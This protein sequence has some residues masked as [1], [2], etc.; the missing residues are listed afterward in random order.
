M[1]IVQQ[2]GGQA[3]PR[4]GLLAVVFAALAAGA[5][6]AGAWAVVFQASSPKQASANTSP[7]ASC[8]ADNVADQSGVNYPN[9]EVEP[10]VDVNPTNAKNIVAAWQQDRW[11]NGGARGLVAGVSSNGGK[12]W[13]QVVI[14]GLVACSGNPNFKRAS[15]PWVSFAP[16]GDLYQLALTTSGGITATGFPDSG[17]L[18]SKS[19]DG[20]QTWADPIALKTDQGPNVLNDK[21]SIT[22]DANDAN[23]AYAV[24]DRLEEG[25]GSA[26]TPQVFEHAIGFFGPAWF[27]R[28]TNGGQSWEPAR[29]IFDPGGVNQT[30]GNQVAVL[31]SSQG[32]DLL[33][34]FNLIAN[35]K[36]AGGIRGMNVAFVRSTDK[37]ATWSGVQLVDKLLRARVRDPETGQLV[38]TAEFNLD[39]AVDAASG[40]LYAV[41]QDARF[42][43]TGKAGIALSMS[44]DGGATWSPTIKINT[45]PGDVSAFTPAVHVLPD[46]TVGATYYDFRNNTTDPNTLP[47]D[48]WLVHCH[49]SCSSAA[50]WAQETHVAGPFDMKNAP[51]ASGLFVG[52]YEGLDNLG[53][54]FALL[55]VQAGTTPNSA[56]AF[57]STVGP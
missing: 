56:D 28:T 32:G 34:F 39:V 23:F 37:G 49:S 33:D 9:T 48:Y 43:P 53:G 6:A 24:W 55:L 20:G 57:Y 21:Q 10:W 30:I 14:P 47:T 16:N 4:R 25:G 54:S 19:T 42:S 11:S 31:P 3:G 46:G 13:Q 1:G 12:S 26:P 18:V 15:D 40:N 35:F 44:S 50:N 7:F 52:D 36:N 38:R 8:T 17:I 27:S 29:I 22:A 5:V 41:W 45:T 51:Q 2:L